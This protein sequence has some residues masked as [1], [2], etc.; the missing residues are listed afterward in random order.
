MTT[1]EETSPPEGKTWCSARGM[2]RRLLALVFGWFGWPTCSDELPLLEPAW[3]SNTDIADDYVRTGLEFGEAV[4]FLHFGEP[5][6]FEALLSAW[7]AAEET[8]ANRG[9]RTLRLEEFVA[10]AREDN[11]PLV[12]LLEPRA[13]GEDSVLHA[14]AYRLTSLGKIQPSVDLRKIFRSLPAPTAA[15]SRGDPCLTCRAD[16]RPCGSTR[17]LDTRAPRAHCRR[18]ME[19]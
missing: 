11:C 16:K 13:E 6:G 18:V 10:S 7:E 2:L 9:F 1:E 17:S 4:S 8:Y 14:K 15:P 5:D 3:P 19:H 12:G